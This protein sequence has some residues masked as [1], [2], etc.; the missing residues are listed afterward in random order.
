MALAAEIE[1]DDGM[2]DQGRPPPGNE[3]V[4]AGQVGQI[5]GAGLPLAG[6][7]FL[8]DVATVAKVMNRN[9]VAVDVGVGGFGVVGLPVAVVGRLQ[10]EPP[11]GDNRETGEEYKYAAGASGEAGRM[12]PASRRGTVP[13]AE[14]ADWRS[15]RR[16]RARRSP[17]RSEEKLR[18]PEERIRP[19]AGNASR[20]FLPRGDLSNPGLT[21]IRAEALDLSEMRGAW[22]SGTPVRERFSVAIRV[23]NF[24]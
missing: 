7:V 14:L 9:V 3:D 10:R 1:A 19:Y 24:G 6:V 21:S 13:Q 16:S 15:A 5:E 18:I 2:R 22:T 8:G 11:Q 17:M 12:P 23:Y 4:G 20:E